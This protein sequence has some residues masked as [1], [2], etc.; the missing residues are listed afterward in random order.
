[1]SSMPPDGTAI[2]LDLRV[3]LELCIFTAMLMEARSEPKGRRI[4]SLERVSEHNLSEENIFFQILY[5]FV[6]TF[7]SEFADQLNYFE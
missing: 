4:T 6:C 5:F 3:L 7:R 1:M 2:S